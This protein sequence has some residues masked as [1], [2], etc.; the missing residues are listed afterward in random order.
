MT[1]DNT[2]HSQRKWYDSAHASLCLLGSY[3]RQIGF[4]KPLEQRVKIQQ[5]VLKYWRSSSIGDHGEKCGAR[6]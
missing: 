4:F 6:Y 3:L 2:A 1:Q 5:K